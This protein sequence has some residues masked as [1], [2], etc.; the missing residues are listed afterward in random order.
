MNKKDIDKL[1]Q[2]KL[3]DYREVP[4]DSVWNS[5][6]ESLDKKK[7]SRRVIPIWWKLGGAAAVLLIALLIINPFGGGEIP[8]TNISDTEELQKTNPS[9]DTDNNLN[10]QRERIVPDAS[11]IPP[12][13]SSESGITAT[14]EKDSKKD[15]IDS[16]AEQQFADPALVNEKLKRS[17]QSCSMPMG[18]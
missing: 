12:D 6:E 13:A 1:F 15:Q 8:N 9:T 11:Q 14:E 7:K 17:Q 18:N 3:R 4:D 16:E 10:P 5:I 2:E